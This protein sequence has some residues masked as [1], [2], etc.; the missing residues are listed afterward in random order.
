M[1]TVTHLTIVRNSGDGPLPE[2]LV[3]SRDIFSSRY[4]GG[5]LVLTA[6]VRDPS[7]P[8]TQRYV[9]YV[10]RTWVDGIRALWRPFVE[11]RVK[12]Q[13]KKVFAD[14]RERLERPGEL[15]TQ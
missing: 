8:P 2:V 6:L 14:V 3:I 15:S 10:N 9:V 11:Y 5:S 12:S 7:S 4:T 13:A 1:I